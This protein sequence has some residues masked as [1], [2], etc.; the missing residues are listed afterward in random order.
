MYLSM[1]NLM[2]YFVLL[3]AERSCVVRFCCSRPLARALG[4]LHYVFQ[5]ARFLQTLEQFD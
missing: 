2:N 4:G 3:V 1:S 5:E